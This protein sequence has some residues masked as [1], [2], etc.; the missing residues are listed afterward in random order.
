[1]DEK[2]SGGDV[3][4]NMPV[5]LLQIL[6]KRKSITRSES[7]AFHSVGV[8]GLEPAASCSQSRHTANCTT[9]RGLKKLIVIR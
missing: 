4:G 9:P 8:A 6:S 7:D 3:K 5:S 2:S 1:V